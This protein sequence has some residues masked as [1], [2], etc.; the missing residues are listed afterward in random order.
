[1]LTDVAVRK[2]KAGPKPYKM[3]D[4][5]GLY[6]FVT[7]TGT[8][9]WRL[10][11]RFDGRDKMKTLGLYPGVSLSAARDKRDEARRLLRLGIDP[12][13]AP[14][15]PPASL[16]FEEAAR[17]WHALNTPRWKPAHA[18]HLLQELVNDIFPR[19]GRKL[20]T[21][22]DAPMVL[23]TLR[24]VEARGAIDTARRLRQRISAVFVYGI[25]SGVC[26]NDPAAIIA[27]A[28]APMKIARHRP[29]VTTI[30]EARAVL[31]ACDAAAGMPRVK[32]AMRLLALT[33]VRPGEVAGAM[34]SEFEGLDGT[35]PLWRIPKERMKGELGAQFEHLVPLSHQAVAVIATVRALGDSSQHVFPNR[36]DL[37]TSMTPD[38]LGGLLVRAGYAGKHVPHGWRSAVSTIMNETAE[39]DDR[40]G[41]RAIIDL[42]LAHTPKDDVEKAY[43]R[44]AY[45]PRRREIAAAWAVLL[46][47]SLT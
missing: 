28:M 8:R 7:V 15:P 27:K 32:L 10:K 47:T 20:L 5:G 19:L 42:M 16:T 24:H 12:A 18:T 1:M 9:S 45:M 25:A 46:E 23:A 43:N 22:I 33:A 31:A 14:P 11:Y 35:A 41:D 38:A 37:Q 40:A 44:S 6:C 4:S 21:E 3:G 29:A 30:A 39:R 34:W 17:A 2:A 36:Y 26:S 13:A